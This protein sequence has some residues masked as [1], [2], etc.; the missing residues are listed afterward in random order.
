MIRRMKRLLVPVLLLFVWVWTL[1][2]G[3]ASPP[4]V[5]VAPFSNNTGDPAWDRLSLGLVDM[6]QS[7]LRASKAFQIVERAGLGALEG[8]HAL[9]SGGFIDP[10]TASEYGRGLAAT[11]VLTGGYLIF[12]DQLRIDA[13]LVSVETSEIVFAEQATGSRDAFFALEAQLIEAMHAGLALELS[14]LQ[15]VQL[16]RRAP[17]PLEAIDSYSRALERMDL[18]EHQAAKALLEQTIA[19]APEFERAYLRMDEVEAALNALMSARQAGLSGAALEAA[20]ALVEYTPAACDTFRQVYKAMLLD[21]AEAEDLRRPPEEIGTRLHRAWAVLRY[22]Q[23]LGLPDEPCGLVA[24]NDAVVVAFLESGLGPYVCSEAEPSAHESCVAEG[25]A[26][27]DDAGEVALEPE[28]YEDLYQELALDYL[29]RFPYGSQA[30]QIGRKAEAYARNKRLRSTTFEAVTGAV[31]GQFD[32]QLVAVEPGYFELGMGETARPVWVRAPFLIG[33]TEVT[34]DL[35][36]AVMKDNP[37]T[38]KDLRQPVETVDFWDA[39]IFCNRLSMLEGLTPAY[40]FTGKHPQTG[41][42]VDIALDVETREAASRVSWKLDADGYRLPTRAE[43]ELAARAGGTWL[44]SDLAEAGWHKGNSEQ[45]PHPVAQF[46]PNPFGLYDMAGNVAEW[47]WDTQSSADLGTINRGG[48]YSYRDKDYERLKDVHR[49]HEG[50]VVLG[51]GGWI[52]HESWLDPRNH[53]SWASRKANESEIGLRVVRSLG[54][55]EYTVELSEVTLDELGY[56]ED[57]Y[58]RGSTWLRGSAELLEEKLSKGR[59]RGDFKDC[60]ARLRWTDPTWTGSVHVTVAATHL[61]NPEGVLVQGD[62]R[63]G[64]NLGGCLE[65]SIDDWYWVWGDQEG[66]QGQA[67][68]RLTFAQV[69]HLHPGAET[70]GRLQ[71][72]L[73][74]EGLAEVRRAREEELLA[75]DEERL[76]RKRTRTGWPESP[77]PGLVLEPAGYSMVEVPAGTFEMGLRG[78]DVAPVHTVTLTRPLLAGRTEVTQA[79]YLA[80][81]DRTGSISGQQAD[82][83]LPMTGLSYRDA[84]KFCNLLSRQEGLTPTYDVERELIRRVPDADGYRLPTEAEWEYLARAGQRTAYAGSDKLSKVAWCGDEA[85]RS[86]QQVALR[87][88]NAWG[89]HD[90][91]GNVWEWTD[92][93]AC[94]LDREPATDPSC[95]HGAWKRVKRGG[96]YGSDPEH[97]GVAW[98]ASSNANDHRT[99]V[100]FR[101]VRTPAP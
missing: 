20:Q 16:G 28:A 54:W 79:L 61:N 62:D 68:F 11:H 101:M 24:P 52:H 67:G 30:Q 91:S 6:L 22:V 51:G 80:V 55:T 3:S 99:T 92:D 32:H 53:E 15:R 93:R 43:W 13:R 72:G 95:Q 70:P 71:A 48:Y 12:G 36:E 4:V 82:P 7:D 100:G 78:L 45:R 56:W 86:P 65:R 76:A 42:P 39:M 87:D 84:V 83:Q 35:Y 69:L 85:A 89:F 31:I 9:A 33:T 21:L 73:G 94:D 47:T 14:N 44:P 77:T 37:S 1:P 25:L 8:E 17:A 19:A 50:A 66:P 59:V 64:E 96:Y 2:A 18:G 34:Q 27:R 98:R 26:M 75:R 88:P 5:V 81:Y 60:Y 10:S 58:E 46:P 49:I 57:R 29:K 41:E 74:P 90:L 97:C 38:F 63:A 40:R 23:D